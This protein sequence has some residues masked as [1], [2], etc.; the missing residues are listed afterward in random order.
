MSYSLGRLHDEAALVE[1]RENNRII[2]EAQLIQTSVHSLLSKPARGQFQ[3]MVKSLN[4]VVKA[5]SWLFGEDVDDDNEHTE[6]QSV[7]G[8]EGPAK[9][10]LW[11]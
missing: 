2:T 10:G 4:V 11:G 7:D 1:E 8:A 5:H 9:K 3:K 6:T